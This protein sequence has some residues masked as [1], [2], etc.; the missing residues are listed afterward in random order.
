M[1]DKISCQASSDGAE[2][3]QEVPLMSFPPNQAQADLSCPLRC[4]FCDINDVLNAGDVHGFRLMGTIT[5]ILPGKNFHISS[6][7]ANPGIGGRPDDENYHHDSAQPEYRTIILDDGTGFLVAIEAEMSMVEK[8]NSPIGTLVDCVCRVVIPK[9]RGHP[10]IDCSSPD[11]AEAM[12]LRSHND[13]QDN[14][15]S[16]EPTSRNEAIAL[17]AEMLAVVDDAHAET[18]RW[19]ELTYRKKIHQ[20]E[21]DAALKDPACSKVSSLHPWTADLLFGPPVSVEITAEDVCRLIHSEF[22]DESRTTNGSEEGLSLEDIALVYD[23]DQLTIQRLLE[24]LQMSGQIYQ[25]VHGA[26]VPL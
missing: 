3:I 2:G 18:L 15:R 23:L 24:E 9:I 10:K 14:A 17:R 8:M 7:G 26:Y 22:S 21:M 25:N 1:K 19:M 4:F 20:E 12:H 11:H 13:F 16:N 6:G 5:E